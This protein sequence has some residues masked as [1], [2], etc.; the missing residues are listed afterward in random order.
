MLDLVSDWE[1]LPSIASIDAASSFG[2]SRHLNKVST[3][4]PCASKR[5][6]KYKILLPVSTAVPCC[7]QVKNTKSTVQPFEKRDLPPERAPP[8]LVSDLKTDREPADPALACV[9]PRDKALSQHLVPNWLKPLLLE[10]HNLDDEQIPHISEAPVLKAEPKTEPDVRDTAKTSTEVELQTQTVPHGASLQQRKATPRGQPS[11]TSS[12]LK[13]SSSLQINGNQL[14]C[15]RCPSNPLP[16]R[17]DDRSNEHQPGAHFRSDLEAK[18]YHGQQPE[19]DIKS[20]PAESSQE[21]GQ[22]SE[23]EEGQ[24]SGEHDSLEVPAEAPAKRKRGERAGKRV[25]Q[26]IAKRAREREERQ[27][28]LETNPHQQQQLQIP[29]KIPKRDRP[30]CK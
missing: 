1:P 26:R 12:K 29:A 19:V 10:K 24:I 23:Q 6:C 18:A 13:P 28:G 7:W 11:Q 17:Q 3:L 5:L 30:T 9:S 8:L 4:V 22:L 25:R 21:E 16:E 14:R 2:K 15:D 20:E 27:L